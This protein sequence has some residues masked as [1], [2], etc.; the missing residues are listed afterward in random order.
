[1]NVMYEKRSNMDTVRDIKS[2]AQTDGVIEVVSEGDTREINGEIVHIDG[3]SVISI[4]D[5]FGDE[6]SQIEPTDIS[7]MS[8]NTLTLYCDCA[9]QIANRVI[10]EFDD[11]RSVEI[12]GCIN[13]A[14]S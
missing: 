6:I 2:V 1:M 14:E 11:S 9:Q 7:D 8:P 12:D 13:S 4:S 10:V 5:Y 3:A